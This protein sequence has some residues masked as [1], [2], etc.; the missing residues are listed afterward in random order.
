MEGICYGKKP[1]YELFSN[2][3]NHCLMYLSL[4]P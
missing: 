4:F 3:N 1:Y 2:E